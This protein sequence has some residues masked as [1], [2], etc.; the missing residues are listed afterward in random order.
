[1]KKN[2]ENIIFV[3]IAIVLIIGCVAIL[4]AQDNAEHK[5]AIT[6]CNGIENTIEKYDST[7]ER[8]WVC[9]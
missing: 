7:G 9:K 5:K 2:Y 8:Y 4:W 1:M 6:R 3:V